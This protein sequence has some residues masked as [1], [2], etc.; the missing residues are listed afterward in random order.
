[1]A[2]ELVKLLIQITPEEDEEEGIFQN[3]PLLQSL[4]EQILL[5]LEQVAPVEPEVLPA[6]LEHPLLHYEILQIEVLVEI[7]QVALAEV[8]AERVD[9]VVREPVEQV[10]RTERLVPMLPIWVEQVNE[11]LQ[12]LQ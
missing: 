4:L 6:L 5:R 9:T 8:E 10:E 3:I 11:R 2:V 12:S 1:M 7:P